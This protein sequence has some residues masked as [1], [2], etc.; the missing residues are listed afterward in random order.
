MKKKS[1]KV[2]AAGGLLDRRSFLLCGLALTTAYPLA[3]IASTG[4]EA[5][6]VIGETLPTWM[7]V[8]GKGA[9]GYGQPSTHE[10]HIGRHLEKNTPETSLFSIWN[11]PIENQR[12]II[13]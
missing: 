10:Q 9:S 6:S 5:H 2:V 4:S 7:K 8:P 1:L 3:S 11:T 13:K 12:G